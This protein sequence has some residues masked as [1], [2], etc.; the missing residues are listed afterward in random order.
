VEIGYKLRF[1]LKQTFIYCPYPDSEK[2]EVLLRDYKDGN[3]DL[4]FKNLLGYGLQK[5]Y[6]GF[7]ETALGYMKG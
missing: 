2:I 6:L 7:L 1:C 3:N 5:V 4:E